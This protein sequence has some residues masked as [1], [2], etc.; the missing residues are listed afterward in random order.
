M[1]NIE[2][3][4][5]KARPL[6]EV[7]AAIRNV[8][9][10]ERYPIDSL[11]PLLGEAAKALADA[12]QVPPE[13]A[14]QSVLSVGSF[15]AQDKYNIEMDGRVVPLSLNL[16]TVALSGDRKSACDKVAAK[17]LMDWQHQR[18]KDHLT[19]LIS[20]KNALA[21]Y[22]FEHAAIV[23][24]K[25]QSVL[26]KAV[27]IDALEVPVAPPDAIVICQEPTLEG[28]Q[29]SFKRGMPS[30]ALF[31]D[32][33]AQFFG[34]HAMK[35]ENAAK[36]IAGLSKYW[37]GAPIIRTRAGDGESA[38]ML[39]RRL[40]MHLLVQPIIAEKV[41]NDRLL[42]EQ[43]LLARFLIVD[44]PSIAGTRLYNHKNAFKQAGVQVFHKRL[45]ELLEIRPETDETG[46]L[47]LPNLLVDEEAQSIWVEAYDNT[48]RQILPGSKLEVIQASASKAAENAL[49]I[50]GVFAVVENTKTVNKGQMLRAWEL[51]AF[52]MDGTLMT[53]RRQDASDL[54]RDAG[55]IYDWIKNQGGTADI[56]SMQKTLIPKRH[57]KSVN[58]IRGI[59][60]VL[61]QANLMKVSGTNQKGHPCK[62]RAIN[63][64]S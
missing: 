59:M 62:W 39:D 53:R 30:Q 36:T 29:K 2:E 31:T 45:V 26:Q 50:A 51:M 6:N 13:I 16:L 3:F 37:D 8:S 58:H 4:T 42:Q 17:P 11:G 34:G 7:A 20:H 60:K 41:L 19:E 23:K 25:N 24:D 54:E 56:V 43:G 15:A 9:G 12:V 38:M 1:S 63:N 5:P 61:E 33:G 32:E 49:R 52:Y 55:E 18:L 40:A 27:S 35:A 48:E 22:E 21:I 44:A 47:I 64:E 28:I 14:A 46:G 10:R 57:R